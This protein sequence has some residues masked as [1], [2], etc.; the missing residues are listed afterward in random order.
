VSR[1]TILLADVVFG[2]VLLGIAFAG[3]LRPPSQSAAPGQPSPA[4]LVTQ[5]S[6]LMPSGQSTGFAVAH[7]GSLAIVDRGREAV[8]RMDATGRVQNEWSIPGAIDLVGIAQNGEDWDV[9][10]R[11]ALRIDRLDAQGRLQ[12]DR[13]IDL[14]QLGTYGP[15]GLAADGNGD[16]FLADTGRDRLVVFNSSG[17]TSETIGDSGNDLGKFKQPMFLAFAPDGSFYVS[18]WENSRIQRFDANRQAT[19]AWQVPVHAWGVAVDGLGRVFAPDGDHRLVRIYGPDGTLLAQIGADPSTAIPVDGISQVGVS[20]DNGRLWVLGSDGLAV[21]DL[22]PYAAL[23]PASTQPVRVPLALL[24]AALLVVAGVSATL[25]RASRDLSQRARFTRRPRVSA[26]PLLAIGGI[27][28]LAAEFA[29]NTEAAKTDPWPR[30]AALAAFSLVFAT[31]AVL[32]PRRR[33][34]ATWPCITSHEEGRDLKVLAL[35]PPSAALAATA[36]WIWSHGTFQ[37]PDATRAALL[38]LAS[39]I[40]M[41]AA[42][43]S[44][45]RLRRPSLWTLIPVGLFVLALLPRAWNNADLP[46]G[47]WFDEAEAGLQARTFLHTGLYTP[48]TD[49]YGRDAS[50]FYYGIS[51]AQALIP[52]PVEAGRLVAAIFGAA[53]APLVYFLGRELFGWPVGLVAGLVL[54]TQRWHLDVSRLGWDPI[55]L[56]FFAILGFW[57]LALALRTCSWRNFAWAG[58]ALGLG[59]HAYIG[60]RVLPLVAAVLLL[61]GGFRQRWAPT[62]FA[63]RVAITLAAALLTALPVVIFA[64]QDPIAFN[65]RFAQTLILAEPV[66]TA[67]K[68]AE[69]WSNVQKHGLMF[70]VSGDMNG[71]HN[72]PGAPMLDATSGLLMMLGLAQCVVRF[73]DW[74]SWLVFGWGLASMAGGVFTIPYEA[75]QAMRTLGTT[76]LLALL[77]ALGA[78][79]VLDRL[80]AFVPRFDW[81]PAVA[82]ATAVTL[83]IGSSNLTMFFGRQMNDPTVWESFSTRETLPSR[84]ALAAPRPYETILGSQTIA[85]SLEQRLMVPDLQNTIQTFDS[86]RDLP[87]PGNG[88]GLVILESEHDTGLADQV[89][90]YYPD[91][92]RTPVLAPNA[93]SPTAYEIELTPA[94]IAAHRGLASSRLSDGSYRADLAVDVN[95]EYAFAFSTGTSVTVDGAPL[96]SGQS[97]QLV[98][99]NH[100]LTLSGGS[101]LQWRPPNTNTFEAV[102]DDRLFAAPDGGN[103][104]LATFYPTQDFQGGP[105]ESIIDGVLAHYYHLSPLARLNLS[106]PRWSA[107]WV[108][109]L[110]APTTGTYRF[111]ADRLSRAGLWLDNQLVFDDTPEGTAEH[112]SGSIALTRGRHSIRVRMQDR[113]DGGPRLYLYWSPP[114][115]TRELVPGSVLYPPPPSA[116]SRKD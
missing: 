3:Q 12:P 23:R 77:V 50:L 39:L 17:A 5:F 103:G 13:A 99:G 84:A 70:H 15:N 2:L 16:L 27:G 32:T 11:G 30:M 68:V 82:V 10:D 98:R 80:A 111:E 88:P 109:E 26:A 97:V 73:F 112:Q 108:G 38:W 28:A 83:A 110:D 91:A 66:P 29:V 89:S 114:G 40:L 105:T 18:D 65:G 48:I 54:A 64:V 51:A 95:G 94:V 4:Q 36:G 69:I 90:R 53:C 74:R 72:L 34:I 87:Y 24:G 14:S 106:P 61:Y 79:L 42:L 71:R 1:A 75:P 92:M 19:N 35:S 43:G 21:V 78:V 55:S 47:V 31:G 58:L 107:E 85:P 6:G 41:L 20:P 8:L 59:M 25:T 86:T 62:L 93:T 7:D 57:L 113:G 76:P 63:G 37:T 100:L 56:P 22:A 60:F 49:T 52:D 45:A 81:R 116:V 33:W 102:P 46:F 67:Q 96:S 44:R 101:D 115:G 9:L 104:L